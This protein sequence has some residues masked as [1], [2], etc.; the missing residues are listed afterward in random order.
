MNDKTKQAL[1]LAS[2]ELQ[3]FHIAGLARLQTLEAITA[4]KEAIALETVLLAEQPTQQ[5]IPDLIAGALGVSRGTAYDLMRE[6]LAA[7]QQEPLNR[8]DVACDI[9]TLCAI[10]D[11]P[12]SFEEV[13]DWIA[14][15]SMPAQQQEPV[16]EVKLKERG[17]NAGIA[18]VIHEIFDPM[19]EPLR[20]GDKL[21]ASPP[22]S[23]PLTDEQIIRLVPGLYDCLCDPYDCDKSGDDYASIPKDMIR[24]ARAIEAAHGITGEQK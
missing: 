2:E 23:K 5:D 11:L 12:D 6:A 24:L 21:Y 10:G 19:R 13:A 4:I 3:F 8:L 22:A 16:A 9:K 20:V 1:E 14:D 7:A 17:G 18:T 15:G